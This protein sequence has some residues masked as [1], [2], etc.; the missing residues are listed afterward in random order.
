MK[1]TLILAA[2]LFLVCGVVGA[3]GASA[4]KGKALF[5]NPRLGGGTTGNSCRTCH[6]GGKGL[7]SGLFQPGTGGEQKNLP[8]IVNSCIENTLGGSPID[9]QGEEMQD[10]IAYI[11][12]LVGGPGEKN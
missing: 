1:K 10:L 7:S 4:E 5:E 6:D 2:S 12:T 8:G 3:Y 9:P 11:K